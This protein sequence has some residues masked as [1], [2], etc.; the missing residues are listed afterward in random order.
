M[1]HPGC[2]KGDVKSVDKRI[3]VYYFA[4]KKVPLPIAMKANKY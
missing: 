4:S 1:Q 3:M 2:E